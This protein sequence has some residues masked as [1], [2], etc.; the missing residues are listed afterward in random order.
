MP[1]MERIRFGSQ[2]REITSTSSGR[3][4]SHAV[5]P[6]VTYQCDRTARLCP[7]SL[8]HTT[9]SAVVRPGRTLPGPVRAGNLASLVTASR[10]A[11]AVLS[12]FLDVESFEPLRRQLIRY[13]LTDADASSRAR[14]VDVFALGISSRHRVLS[15]LWRIDQDV[16]W[17]E[18][19]GHM[20]TLI[21]D[22][23]RPTSR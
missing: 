11:A 1:S 10:E 12:S 16:D 19:S 18:R 15:F 14:A 8:I 7:S 2:W 6:W 13:G 5:L 9:I 20:I 4:I 22:G 23:L 21:L 3:V 17:D